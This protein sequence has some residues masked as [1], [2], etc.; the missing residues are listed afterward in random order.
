M[1][2]WIRTQ[3]HDDVCLNDQL[4]LWRTMN[5]GNATVCAAMHEWWPTDMIPHLTRD[6]GKAEG[7][8]QNTPHSLIEQEF[9]IVAPHVEKTTNQRCKHEDCNC[10]RIVW[11]AEYTDLN[12][13]TLLNPFCKRFS[14]VAG[15]LNVHSISSYSKWEKKQAKREEQKKMKVWKMNF[16]H[17]MSTALT[18]S[19]NKIMQQPIEEI[20]RKQIVWQK[21]FLKKKKKITKYICLLIRDWSQNKS[22]LDATSLKRHEDIQNCHIS[23]F[24]H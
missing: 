14:H 9:Q 20:L 4:R 19:E 5:V 15:S 11:W 21:N 7:K 16:L 10:S 8:R 6:H 3:E 22:N 18:T 1:K 23:E 13:G 2:S 24:F 12:I 17:L